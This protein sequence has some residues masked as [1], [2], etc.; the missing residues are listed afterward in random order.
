MDV[1]KHPAISM[2]GLGSLFLSV[3]ESS[4]LLLPTGSASR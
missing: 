3:A 2:G 4:S 1:E